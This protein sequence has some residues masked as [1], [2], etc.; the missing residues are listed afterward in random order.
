[1][2]IVAFCGGVNFGHAGAGVVE[3]GL[4]ESPLSE[5]KLAIPSSRDTLG[6][7]LRSVLNIR[8]IRT[9]DFRLARASG[10]L[11]DMAVRGDGDD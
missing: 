6:D 11:V 2:G 8:D 10:A 3:L 1:M 4:A 9:D 7:Q 5:S